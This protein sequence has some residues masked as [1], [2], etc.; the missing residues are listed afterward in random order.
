VIPLP[1]KRE[2]TPEE[3][4]Q[5]AEEVLPALGVNAM[6]ADM[7]GDVA[8]FTAFGAAFGLIMQDVENGKNDCEC[9]VCTTLRNAVKAVGFTE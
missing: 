1:R 6:V 9:N 8:A 2:T 4:L 7:G 5:A 3:M